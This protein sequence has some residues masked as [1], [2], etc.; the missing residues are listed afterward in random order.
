MDHKK[1]FLEETSRRS[2]SEIAGELT[3]LAAEIADGVL[4]ISGEKLPVGDF[5][6]FVMKKK[7]KKGMISCEFFLQTKMMEKTRSPSVA[8]TGDRNLQKFPASGGKKLKKDISRLWKD[9][10]KQVSEESVLS[11]ELAIELR[12]KCDGYHPYAHSKW[13]DGWSECADKVK[14]CLAA[15]EKGDFAEARKNI[16]E[17]NHLTKQ[18]H[19]LYK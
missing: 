5:F 15:A 11:R 7:L 14:A 12:N 16:S 17:V 13:F 3:C 1:I 19:R 2:G 10:V 4:I 8:N 6:S 9:V 18:C